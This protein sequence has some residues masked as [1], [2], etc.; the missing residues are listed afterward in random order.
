MPS[1]L[2]CRRPDKTSRQED[3]TFMRLDR[4][5]NGKDKTFRHSGLIQRRSGQS[6]GQFDQASRQEDDPGSPGVRGGVPP[7]VNL[8][9]WWLERLSW[10]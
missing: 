9:N 8:G 10:R 2:P 5:L 4:L 6:R 1:G 3:K 7:M